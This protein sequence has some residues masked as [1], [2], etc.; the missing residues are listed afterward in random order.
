MTENDRHSQN[1][2]VQ[3]AK[4][5]NKKRSS[6]LWVVLRIC[7]A[8]VAL[9]VVTNSIQ[10]CDYLNGPTDQLR[11]L[12]GPDN[13]LRVRNPDG[14][15]FTIDR[16][17]PQYANYKYMPGAITL[18]QDLRIRLAFCGVM[19]YAVV[20]V[21]QAT[22]W[23]ILLRIQQIVISFGTSLKLTYAGLFSS[24]FLVGTTAGDLVKA[25][26]LSR[27]SPRR[28]ETFVSVFIDRFIG[29]A[30]VV[31]VA[32]VLVLVLRD[33]PMVANLVLPVWTM[34]LVFVVVVLIL[35]SF[36]IRH[37]IRF[38][39]WSSKLPLNSLINKIDQSLLA[40]RR[41]LPAVR[42][43]WALTLT[44]QLLSSTSVYF[45][46]RGLQIDGTL[47]QFWFFVPLAFLVASIPI[48][49]FWGLGL[50]EGAYVALFAG[51]G[52]ATVTQAAMLAM[53]VRLTQLLWS[54]PGSY[55]LM[56]GLGNSRKSVEP[57]DH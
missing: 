46:G 52:L 25:Y 9:G 57:D 55:V 2:H 8:V 43:A 15:E 35:F 11:I 31:L 30:V 16:S 39:R 51:S 40:C 26:W 42:R 48:S 37:L 29:G 13:A 17:S 50:L 22:R 41:N 10:F 44:L 7:F 3:Q 6:R 28:T 38:D 45:V 27:N 53:A 34:L 56:R 5:E 54:L 1:R 33:E 21:L 49:V 20:P 14:R 19:I 23:R 18:V 32:G 4:A 36:K 47:W 24:F 12:G